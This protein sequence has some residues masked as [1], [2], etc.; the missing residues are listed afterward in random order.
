MLIT[1]TATET[2]GTAT[3]AT[4]S[5]GRA[6]IARPT[7]DRWTGRMVDVALFDANRMTVGELITLRAGTSHRLALDEAVNKLNACEATA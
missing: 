4:L 1:V 5:D 2:A 3:I 7:G 6:I